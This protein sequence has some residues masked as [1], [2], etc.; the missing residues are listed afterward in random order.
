MI[1]TDAWTEDDCVPTTYGN[2]AADKYDHGRYVL[3]QCIEYQESDLDLEENS[4]FRL[5]DWYV[6]LDELRQGQR[7]LVPHYSHS[8]LIKF[9]K[10]LWNMLQPKLGADG[11]HMMSIVP[12]D[13]EGCS[14]SMIINGFAVDICWDLSEDLH[15]EV[16]AMWDACGHSGMFAK[17][18]EFVNALMRLF[19]LNRSD[20]VVVEDGP[21]VGGE[22][23]FWTEELPGPQD[24]PR[25]LPK[26][27]FQV[28]GEGAEYWYT[29]RTFHSSDVEVGDVLGILHNYGRHPSDFICTI[30]YPKKDPRNE[31]AKHRNE[32]K[33]VN[34]CA[35]ATH[36]WGGER[37]DTHPEC[38]VW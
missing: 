2:S 36:F 28:P 26:F 22:D 32:F 8:D 10:I 27:N 12:V 18:V 19:F 25:L 31:D 35:W 29:D 13:H 3:R 30:S 23:E 15:K 16:V 4:R 14:S 5:K 24:M 37:S 1:L 20:V 6:N 38:T 21:S 33:K 34:K 9:I 7:A 11:K 17:R